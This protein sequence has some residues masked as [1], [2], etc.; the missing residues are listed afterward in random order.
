MTATARDD[1]LAGRLPPGRLPP[2]R[3]AP[4]LPSGHLPRGRLPLGVEMP[5]IVEMAPKAGMALEAEVPPMSPETRARSWRRP[6][7]SS[8]V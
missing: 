5:L 7:L 3:L 2:G 6:W 8:H 1:R 4:G